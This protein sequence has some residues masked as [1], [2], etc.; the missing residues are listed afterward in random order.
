LAF[1]EYNFGLPFIDLPDKGYADY[2]APDWGSKRNHIPL[3]DFFSLSSQRDFTHIPTPFGPDFFR[4]YYT[5]LVNGVYPTPTGPDGTSG[6][7]N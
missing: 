3:S 1:T 4:K 5:T 7:E 6:E 2:N